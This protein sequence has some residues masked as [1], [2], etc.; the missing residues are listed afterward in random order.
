[1]L[2]PPRPGNSGD[3][4]GAPFPGRVSVSESPLAS[5]PAT[6][7]FNYIFH[8]YFLFSLVYIALGAIPGSPPL[9]NL[10]ALYA[11]LTSR[12]FLYSV[13]NFVDALVAIY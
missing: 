5:N 4:A 6:L 3:P 13:C 1:M 7:F 11:L 10:T 12:E 8:F 2:A 9:R